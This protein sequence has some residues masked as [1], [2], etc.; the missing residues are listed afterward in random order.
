MRKLKDSGVVIAAPKEIRY[1]RN[2]WD[3]IEQ[4][5]QFCQTT[6]SLPRIGCIQNFGGITK[7]VA[8][9]V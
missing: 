6:A 7:R 2:C 5:L 4:K 9:L 8:A 1:E 3:E